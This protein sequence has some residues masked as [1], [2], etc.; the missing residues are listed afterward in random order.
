MDNLF[1]SQK[2]FSALHCVQALA[3]GVC[4]TSGR[5]FPPSIK[6]DKV[7]NV[8]EADKLRGAT[9]VGNLLFCR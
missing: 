3:H 1:N 5:G 2:M 7:K 6:Q 8:N 9:I 4:R